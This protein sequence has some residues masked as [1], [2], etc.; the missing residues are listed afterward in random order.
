MKGYFVVFLV[1][2]SKKFRTQ[3][4]Y[5]LVNPECLCYDE[6]VADM[7]QYETKGVF[8]MQKNREYQNKTEELTIKGTAL[9]M[10]CR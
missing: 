4:K 8:A 2:L 3:M 1:I 9:H 5:L 7:I 10:C 6:F